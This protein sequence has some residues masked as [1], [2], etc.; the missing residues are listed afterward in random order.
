MRKLSLTFAHL[1]VNIHKIPS[2]MDLYLEAY[3]VCVSWV[4]VM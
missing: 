2:H 1:I 3:Q 4:D